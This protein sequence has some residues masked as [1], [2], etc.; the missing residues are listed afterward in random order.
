MTVRL[1]TEGK[2]KEQTHL[3]VKVLLSKGWDSTIWHSPIPHV[4][5]VSNTRN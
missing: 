3:G 4:C 2:V 1:F 5:F